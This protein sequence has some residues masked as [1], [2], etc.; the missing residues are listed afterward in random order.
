MLYSCLWGSQESRT[1][2]DNAVDF[3]TLK[4]QNQENGGLRFEVRE[5]EVWFRKDFGLLVAM[6]KPIEFD[7]NVPMCCWASGSLAARIYNTRKQFFCIFFSLFLA[8]LFY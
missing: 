6:N 1:K 8:L 5:R 4:L 3:G 7:H 2:E